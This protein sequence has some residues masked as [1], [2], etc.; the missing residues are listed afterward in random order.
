MGVNAR[1]TRAIAIREKSKR[2]VNSSGRQIVAQLR[3]KKKRLYQRLMNL[4]MSVKVRSDQ[5]Q[6][7]AGELNLQEVPQAVL[8]TK[9]QLNRQTQISQAG[10]N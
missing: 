6:A 9:A 1:K 7:G 5:M 3:R 4:P 2:L 10:N 8:I